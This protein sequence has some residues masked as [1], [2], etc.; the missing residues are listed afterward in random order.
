MCCGLKLQKPLAAVKSL[1]STA[2]AVLLEAA[3]TGQVIDGQLLQK[4]LTI[5]GTCPQLDRERVVC[6]SCQCFLKVKAA[7]T[8]AKCPEGKW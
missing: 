3:K 4:R 7:L 2:V 5:C 8:A 6:N 1:T